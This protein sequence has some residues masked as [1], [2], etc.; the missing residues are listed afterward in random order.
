MPPPPNCCFCRQIGVG[1]AVVLGGG[2]GYVI[3]MIIPL[4][5]RQYMLNAPIPTISVVT[6][7][8]TG[9][10]AHTPQPPVS[11]GQ[12]GCIWGRRIKRK[13]KK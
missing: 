3:D 11:L 8:P 1:L 13:Y 6:V 9:I 5:I 7:Y 4:Q 10:G 2:T 12:M